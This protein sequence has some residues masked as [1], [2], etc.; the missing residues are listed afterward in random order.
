MKYMYKLMTNVIVFRVQK[1]GLRQLK[2]NF[3][4]V[5]RI[6]KRSKGVCVR[7]LQILSEAKALHQ[8]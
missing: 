2:Y 1:I 7:I 6:T 5:E 4:N 8:L 3:A